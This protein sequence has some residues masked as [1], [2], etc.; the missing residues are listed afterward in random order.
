MG[1]INTRPASHKNKGIHKQ[2]EENKPTI[3]SEIPCV[4]APL[5]EPMQCRKMS[6]GCTDGIFHAPWHQRPPLSQLY[7]FHWLDRS[8]GSP[9][10]F[11]PLPGTNADGRNGRMKCKALEGSSQKLVPVPSRRILAFRKG[12][13]ISNNNLPE[14]SWLP[15][16]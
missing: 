7:F 10:A 15:R 6:Q 8:A 16:Y 4:M 14:K 11:F 12:I 3:M 13:R 9:G 1:I 5:R 2:I